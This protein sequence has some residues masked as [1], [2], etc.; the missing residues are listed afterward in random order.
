MQNNSRKAIEGRETVIMWETVKRF[1]QRAC[2]VMETIG[3]LYLWQLG[4]KWV[5]DNWGLPLGV[6]IG[7]IS[8]A[9][10]AALGFWLI[11]GDNKAA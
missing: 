1:W 11:K 8:L 2:R 5:V 7:V 10:L 6:V 3:I 4:V 9:A